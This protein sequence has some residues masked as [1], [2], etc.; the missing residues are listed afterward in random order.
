[1]EEIHEDSMSLAF[2]TENAELWCAYCDTV[3]VHN[4]KPETGEFFSQEGHKIDWATGNIEEQYTTVVWAR[5]SSC[6]KYFN[7]GDM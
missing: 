2:V 4:S 1:M 3:K 6:L 7:K 5:C